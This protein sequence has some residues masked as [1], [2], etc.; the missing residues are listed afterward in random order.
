MT[1]N[2]RKIIYKIK[3]LALPDMYRP[4]RRPETHT[5]RMSHRQTSK[6]EVDTGRPWRAG[7]L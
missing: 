1:Q 6:P 2:R 7:T 5:V 4:R 3:T